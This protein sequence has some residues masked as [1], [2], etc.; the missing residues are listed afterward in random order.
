MADVSLRAASKQFGTITA[1]EHLDL[2]VRDGEFLT[3]LGPSGCGKTTTL[4]IIA[5]FERPTGG[6]VLIGGEDVTVVPPRRRN[7]GMVFQ[8]YALFPHLTVAANI[9]F[10]LRERGV[11]RETIRVRV[12]ELL[13]LVRLPDVEHRFPAEL[14]GGQ[15]QRVALARALA[16]APRVLLMDEPL[17]ALDLKLR[18]AMQ[19]ELHRI[20]RELSI[21]T[22]YVT[23]DQ[24]EA[25]SLSDRIAV[26]AKGRVLQLGTAEEL[27]WRPAST[28]VA[29]FVGKINLLE[30][31]VTNRDGRYWWVAIEAGKAV[32][33]RTEQPVAAGQPVRVAVRP[34]RVRLARADAADL[35][36]WLSGVVERRR[37]SGNRCH[38]FVRVSSGQ[39]LVVEESGESNTVKVGDTV[40]VGWAADDCIVFP[41]S[42]GVTG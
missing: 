38:Y 39:T 16:Y 11:G 40:S 25:M 19:I 21:T 30:G 33:V 20:H 22:I 3:L 36:N 27:Y 8:D 29:D 2:D 23:H 12:R 28:F 4:R 1:V 9:G 15:Q 32:R 14:S 37:F 42:P 24:E 41:G 35:D 17:G 7:I 10:S 13:G 34:E 26:M 18:E 31:A 6:R 5:G